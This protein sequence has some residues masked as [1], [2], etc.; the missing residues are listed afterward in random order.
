MEC[1]KKN[2][3]LIFLFFLLFFLCIM[4]IKKIIIIFATK[5]NYVNI[6]NR[7]LFGTN[8]LVKLVGQNLEN[9]SLSIYAIRLN[10]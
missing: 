2:M 3:I 5:I 4:S 1:G 9:S 8:I 6:Y 7:T 10:A